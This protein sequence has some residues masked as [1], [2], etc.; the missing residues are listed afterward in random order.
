MLYTNGFELVA[1]LEI[2][3]PKTLKG[4]EIKIQAPYEME[5]ESTLFIRW[6]GLVNF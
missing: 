6:G 1:E 3:L 2:Q 4:P 5:N